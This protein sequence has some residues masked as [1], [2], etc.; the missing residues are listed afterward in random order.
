[1]NDPDTIDSAHA[2]NVL[3]ARMREVVAP[4]YRDLND[5]QLAHLLYKVVQ[6]MPPLEREAFADLSLR[7]AEQSPGLS[8]QSM[9]RQVGSAMDKTGQQLAPHA[10]SAARIGAP[11]VGT[12]VA[13]P[14]G[15]ALAGQLTQLLLPSTSPPPTSRSTPPPPPGATS[16][17]GGVPA[18]ALN[19]AAM[20]LATLLTSPSFIQALVGGI[21]G[22][23]GQATARPQVHEATFAIPFEA[24]MKTIS[25]IAL[26]AADEAARQQQ[27]VWKSHFNHGDAPLTESQADQDQRILELMRKAHD[28]QYATPA[29][30]APGNEGHTDEL[31]QWL[32]QTGL[33]T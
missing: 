16:A 31:T 8:F 3:L 13:G 24:M 5:E 27:S 26:Q 18:S 15:G 32:L 22:L 10:A 21:L 23:S 28:W 30:E 17:P 19:S 2:R 6:A 14:L 9:F 11:L 7:L 20:Q 33:L 4:F 29:T 25:E 1:M 12:A